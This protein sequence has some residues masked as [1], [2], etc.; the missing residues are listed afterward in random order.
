M[1]EREGGVKEPRKGSR[2]W[3]M[4]SGERKGSGK[5]REGGGGEEGGSA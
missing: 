1:A 4:R 3:R 5:R 2:E